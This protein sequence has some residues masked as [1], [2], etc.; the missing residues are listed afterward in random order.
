[1]PD[2]PNARGGTKPAPEAPPVEDVFNELT[3]QEQ[4]E[5]GLLPETPAP[6]LRGQGP[7]TTVRPVPPKPTK[8]TPPS[9]ESTMPGGPQG[10]TKPTPT[11]EPAPVAEATPT[12]S[13]EPSALEQ[14]LRDSLEAQSG[15]DPNTLR[16][17]R[18]RE[19][20]RTTS[21]ILKRGGVDLPEEGVRKA[22]GDSAS[23]FPEGPRGR[24]DTWLREHPD[25]TPAEIKAYAHAKNSN[26]LSRTHIAESLRR[27][28]WS[29]A[30]I[31]ELMNTPI[32]E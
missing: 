27:D 15:G 6:I 18:Q 20:A 29:D 17:M 14:Q 23:I 16:V 4:L 11:A 3:L 1:M 26:A 7:P 10:G 19:G 22:S 21:Q 2:S 25:A 32:P 9:F 28:G 5:S 13:A 30:A 8:P 31:A 24:I 12:P